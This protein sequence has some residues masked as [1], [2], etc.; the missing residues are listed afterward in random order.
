MNHLENG[1]EIHPLIKVKA[2]DRLN[3][4]DFVHCVESSIEIVGTFRLKAH[5]V[6]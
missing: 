4:D 5:F 1:V 6:I 3:A 2:D